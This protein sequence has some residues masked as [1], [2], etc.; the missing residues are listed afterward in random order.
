MERILNKLRSAQ[1]KAQEMRSATT[2]SQANQV[3]KPMKKILFERSSPIVSLENGEVAREVDLCAGDRIQQLNPEADVN[4]DDPTVSR[5][6]EDSVGYGRVRDGD[7]VLRCLVQGVER[8]PAIR[9]ISN[10]LMMHIQGKAYGDE[11][12]RELVGGVTGDQ[13][14]TRLG[15]H[16]KKP[17]LETDV[18]E[19]LEKPSHLCHSHISS[20]R[21]GLLLVDPW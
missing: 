21:D 17:N 18:A 1:K 2:A 5:A 9:R 8:E 13:V 6:K 14:P 3:A 15:R 12:M 4:G 11:T 10:H 20:F 7:G 19:L 16:A